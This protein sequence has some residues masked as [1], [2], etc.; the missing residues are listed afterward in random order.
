MHQTENMFFSAVYT[1]DGKQCALPF[2]YKGITYETCTTVD[3]LKYWCPTT[4]GAWGYCDLS[5]AFSKYYSV[6][7]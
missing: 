4:D 6:T 7:F 3:E 5:Q 1:V 2:T